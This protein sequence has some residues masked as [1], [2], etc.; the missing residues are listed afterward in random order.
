MDSSIR[1]ADGPSILRTGLKTMFYLQ[2]SLSFIKG[3]NKTIMEI[4]KVMPFLF[5]SKSKS[6]NIPSIPYSSSKDGL[7]IVALPLGYETAVGMTMFF[8]F[9][10]GTNV[11]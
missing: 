1:I 4:F 6:M 11:C 5:Q 10:L 8:A 7:R 2:S 9:V 3:M